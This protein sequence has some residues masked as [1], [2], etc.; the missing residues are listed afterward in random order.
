MI[1]LLIAVIVVLASV[2]GWLFWRLQRIERNFGVFFQGSDSKPVMQ[3]LNEFAGTI[4]GHTQDIKDLKQYL[5][6]TTR[7][8]E[9]AGTRIGF[10]RFNPFNDTGGDQ[11]FC[12]A[13]IDVQGNGYILSSIHARTGTRVYSKQIQHGSSSHNLSEEEATALTKALKHNPRSAHAS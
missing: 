10:V 1:S 5:D 11:S 8:A 4:Q 6:Q 2:N 12:L 9:H 13:V 7:L 3:A